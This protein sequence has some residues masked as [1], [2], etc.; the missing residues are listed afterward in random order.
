M[1]QFVL[2]ALLIDEQEAMDVLTALKTLGI[3]I[4]DGVPPEE[5]DRQQLY[6]FRRKALAKLAGAFKGR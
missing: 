2:E 3:S 6:Y 1:E 4:K 5:V